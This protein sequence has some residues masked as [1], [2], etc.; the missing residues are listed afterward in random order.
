M[1][2]RAFSLFVCGWRSVLRPVV[3]RSARCV[4]FFI[5]GVHVRSAARGVCPYFFVGVWRVRKRG[6]HVTYPGGEEIGWYL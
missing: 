4:C 3:G 6:A 5:C 1:F 2:E